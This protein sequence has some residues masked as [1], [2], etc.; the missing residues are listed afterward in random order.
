MT[1]PDQ[2]FYFFKTI[3]LHFAGHRFRGQLEARCN[4]RNR[5][6]V[7][8]H[9]VDGLAAVGKLRKTAQQQIPGFVFNKNVFRGQHDRIK[10][11][12]IIRYEHDAL[13]LLNMIEEEVVADAPPE[14]RQRG[15]RYF[16]LLDF[17]DQYQERVM[18][19]IIRTVPIR[20]SRIEQV[21]D[22]CPNPIAVLYIQRFLGSLTGGTP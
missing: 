14:L 20:R 13:V 2:I 1:A 16:T 22:R 8:P 11:H 21:L 6:I 10:G 4:F 18:Q 12:M 3:V 17:A 19:Q 15:S 7:H 5:V 9:Q